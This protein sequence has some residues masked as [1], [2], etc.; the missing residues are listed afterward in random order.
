MRLFG[1]ADGAHNKHDL[2]DTIMMIINIIT[3]LTMGY[4]IEKMLEPGYLF[5]PRL[6][7][8]LS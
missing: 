7:S 3:L 8:T 5:P 1:V 2:P 6:R 4:M